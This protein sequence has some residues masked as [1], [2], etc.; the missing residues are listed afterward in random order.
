MTV[1]AALLVCLGAVQL[2]NGALYATVYLRNPTDSEYRSFAWV[3]FGFALFLLGATQSKT[4]TSAATITP[5]FDL[6]VIGGSIAAAA[7]ATFTYQLLGEKQSRVPLLAH[8]GAVVATVASLMGLISDPGRPSWLSTAAEDLQ[9]TPLGLVWILATV[10]LLLYLAYRSVR[11][12]GLEVDLRPIAAGILLLVVAALHD[13]LKLTTAVSTPFLTEKMTIVPTFLVG[14]VLARRVL[15]AGDR[16]G[17]RSEELRSNLIRLQGVRGD[18]IASQQNA[19]VGGLAAALAH[20]IRNPLAVMR[21]SVSG[22]RRDV[23]PDDEKVL[24]DIVDE[25][26]ERLDRLVLDLR[27]YASTSAPGE[28]PVVLAEI[29]EQAI[30]EAEGKTQPTDIIDFRVS[31]GN[32]P[33]TLWGDPA[34]LKRALVN[35]IAN[36]MQAMPRGGELRVTARA[37][38]IGGA[39]A[40]ELKVRDTGEGMDTL[41]RT[42]AL[43]PFF[44]TRPSGTG[45]GLAIAERVVREHSGQLEVESRYGLGTTVTMQLR[46][47][48]P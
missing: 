20:E 47:D 39:S 42:K 46:C 6:E 22:L 2:Y 3:A 45:L 17:E 15:N 10:V 29:V 19:A 16:L 26:A 33:E 11:G 34:A 32:A 30:A 38:N 21:N 9:L 18:L 14:L 41:V 7:Y 40:I 44:T 24:L 12:A 8:M 5:G 36:G 35:V 28:E 43:D 1:L 4:G 31:L 37:G 25:E 27:S 13:A 48:P 23:G